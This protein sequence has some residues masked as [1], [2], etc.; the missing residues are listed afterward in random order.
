MRHVYGRIYA[1]YEWEQPNE[2]G[3]TPGYYFSNEVDELIGPYADSGT[4]M[5]KLDEYAAKYLREG[6]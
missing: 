4:A 6:P 5:A 2:D 1:Q 3:H